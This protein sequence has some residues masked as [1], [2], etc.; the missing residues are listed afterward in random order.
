[1]SALA[2][3][4][5]ALM[6]SLFDAG[7]D[8]DAGLAIY[9]ASV[10]ANLA[11]ALAA[12]YPVVRRLVGDSFFA[13]AAQRFAIERPSASGDLGEYG[14][15]FARF[16]AGYPHAA[17]LAY[18]PDVAR[19]EWASHECERAA[20]PAPFDFHALSQVPPEAYGDLVL[21]LHPAVR[22]VASVHPVSAIHEANARE[23]DG[24]PGRTEG[25]DWVV[26]RRVDGRAV[27]ETVPPHEWRFLERLAAGDPL[28][29][30]SGLL[31]E[32]IAGE[33]LA[34]ALA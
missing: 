16:L 12:S 19:L 13:E 27:V 18:L 14:E 34:T 23:R 22:L 2:A 32:G 17:G 29:R 20:E 3:L 24:V 1:M 5:R 9:R 15:G 21:Q 8:A 33:F 6:R 31:P 4:Q 7:D 25:A 26:V 11:G 30:A 28:E 10:R